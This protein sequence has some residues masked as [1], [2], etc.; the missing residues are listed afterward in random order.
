MGNVCRGGKI[1]YMLSPK[2]QHIMN[3]IKE[4]RYVMK[5]EQEVQ[6]KCKVAEVTAE[7]DVVKMERDML[8][9]KE[10]EWEMKRDELKTDRDVIKTKRDGLLAEIARLKRTLMMI[11]TNILM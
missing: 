11:V 10:I 6:W 5:M 8:K 4:M 3:E 9:T 1:T 7:R 2:Q